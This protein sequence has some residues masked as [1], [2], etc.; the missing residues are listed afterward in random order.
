MK[1]K[2]NILIIV[3]VLVLVIGIVAVCLFLSFG[4]NEKVDPPKKDDEVEVKEGYD[5]FGNKLLVVYETKEEVYD[6]IT[7][8]YLKKGE[9]IT[10]T[11]EEEGCW[12]YTC[13]NGVDEFIYCIDD[14]VIRVKSTYVM[15]IP[16]K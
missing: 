8:E 3:G 5:E 1:N 6:V 9:T 2:K 12:Y 14:P 16:A 10:F 7:N 15:D 11:K 4:K 13:S